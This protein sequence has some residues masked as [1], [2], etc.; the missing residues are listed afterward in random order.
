MQ[1]TRNSRAGGGEDNNTNGG[2]TPSGRARRLQRQLDA[3]AGPAGYLDPTAGGQPQRHRHSSRAGGEEGYGGHRPRA[4]GSAAPSPFDSYDAVAGSAAAH[5]TASNSLVGPPTTRFGLASTLLGGAGAHSPTNGFFRAMEAS[6]NRY[7]GA[8]AGAA[9]SAGRG[10]GSGGTGV[11]PVLL[12][13]P[14]NNATAL[15]GSGN[16]GATRGSHNLSPHQ[17]QQQQPPSHLRRGANQQQQQQHQH[18]AASGS[19]RRMV[20]S[21]DQLFDDSYSGTPRH[22][23]HSSSQQRGGGGLQHEQQQPTPSSTTGRALQP[24]AHYSYDTTPARRA[25][26]SSANN[27]YTTSKRIRTPPP[28][29]SAADLSVFSSSSSSNPHD[30]PPEEL[31]RALIEEATERRRRRNKQQQED[32][33]Q[34]PRPSGGHGGVVINGRPSDAL[35]DDVAR[36]ELDEAERYN[37]GY[38]YVDLDSSSS[39][40]DDDAE[41]DGNGMGQR[42]AAEAPLFGAARGQVAGPRPSADEEDLLLSPPSV[43]AAPIG[44]RIGRVDRREKQPPAPVTAPLFAARTMADGDDAA[45]IG[46]AADDAV[47]DSPLRQQA[48]P[49]ITHT[50]NGGL[51]REGS[52]LP[53]TRQGAENPIAVAATGE[54]ENFEKQSRTPAARKRPRE[55]EAVGEVNT[56]EAHTPPPSLPF[57]QPSPVPTLASQQHPSATNKK[58]SS[59]ANTSVSGRID[60]AFVIPL[61]P[62]RDPSAPPPSALALAKSN[63]NAHM[64]GRVGGGQQEGEGLGGSSGFERPPASRF[65]RPPPPR[66]RPTGTASSSSVPPALDSGV[67]ATAAS[68]G[69]PEK[70]LVPAPLAGDSHGSQ[71]TSQKPPS[72]TSPPSPR[73]EAITR[74][75]RLP[76]LAPMTLPG[77]DDGDGD[78]NGGE[79]QLEKDDDD[80]IAATGA[81]GDDTVTVSVG[82]GTNLLS[83]AAS[84][85]AA[86]AP[87]TN[88]SIAQQ[89]TRSNS[90]G[91]ANG[92]GS[93]QPTATQDDDD[94]LCLAAVAK[95]TR[96]AVAAAAGRASHS[97]AATHQ[98]RFNAFAAAAAR[99]GGGGTNAAATDY[100]AVKR[101]S[102]DLEAFSSARHTNIYN[103]NGSTHAEVSSSSYSYSPYSTY[104]PSIGRSSVLPAL[105]G[106]PPR[107]SATSYTYSSIFDNGGGSGLA[108]YP[109]RPSASGPKLPLRPPQPPLP[110]APREPAP[111]PRPAIIDRS[112]FINVG[113]SCYAASVFTM[114]LRNRAVFYHLRQFVA[115][116]APVEITRLRRGMQAMLTDLDA[117]IAEKKKASAEV[118]NNSSA[119]FSECSLDTLVTFRRSVVTIFGLS[120]SSAATCI[121]S[122][123][124]DDLAW[125]DVKS[126]AARSSAYAANVTAFDVN[127]LVPAE[128]TARLKVAAKAAPL[129]VPQEVPVVEGD[130]VV[131]PIREIDAPSA[132]SASYSL[133]TS[134]AATAAIIS[135]PDVSEDLSLSIVAPMHHQPP[136][137]PP[138]PPPIADDRVSSTVGGGGR[139]S[140]DSAY[141]PPHGDSADAIESASSSLSL[142]EASAIPRGRATNDGNDDDAWLAIGEEGGDDATEA[143]LQPLA[144]PSVG[145]PLTSFS[146]GELAMGLLDQLHAESNAEAEAEAT[147]T[148]AAAAVK[149]PA[150]GKPATAASLS[151]A[152]AAFSPLYLLPGQSPAQS[153]VSHQ[154]RGNAAAPLYR[155]AKAA[156]PP[157]PMVTIEPPSAASAMRGSTALSHSQ[158]SRPSPAEAARAT[159]LL[160]LHA[161]MLRAGEAIFA[162]DRADEAANEQNARLYEAY[163]YAGRT[164]ASSATSSNSGNTSNGSGHHNA[165]CTPIVSFKAAMHCYKTVAVP[166]W[167]RACAAA[168]RRH[169]RALKKHAKTVSRI[170][171]EWERRQGLNNGEEGGVGAGAGRGGDE[172][173]GS[174]VSRGN[175]G[176]SAA[177]PSGVSSGNSSCSGSEDEYEELVIEG[178]EGP[179]EA[180]LSQPPPP[181]MTAQQASEAAGGPMAAAGGIGINPNA[182]GLGAALATVGAGF[183]DGDQHDAPEFLTAVLARLEEEALALFRWVA[184]ADAALGERYGY[185]SNTGGNGS[186]LGSEADGSL[187]VLSAPH[188]R[189]LGAFPSSSTIAGCAEEGGTVPFAGLSTSQRA[190]LI[191]VTQPEVPSADG[192]DSDAPSHSPRYG[193]VAALLHLLQRSP[194]KDARLAWPNALFQGRLFATTACRAKGSNTK[195]RASA[196]AGGGVADAASSSCSSA[197]GHKNHSVDPFVTFT[198]GLPNFDRELEEGSKAILEAATDNAPPPPP[199]APR[200]SDYTTYGR[201]S[202]SDWSRGDDYYSGTN[203]GNAQHSAVSA[204]INRQIEFK[205]EVLRERIAAR[206]KALRVPSAAFKPTDPATCASSSTPPKGGGNSHLLSAAT[207]DSNTVPYNHAATTAAE[208]SGEGGG[209][210]PPFDLQRLIARG[211]AEDVVD[212]YTCDRCGDKKAQFVSARFALPM[213][214]ALVVN[215]KR[216][217]T[218]W[219]AVRQRVAI[220]KNSCGVRV[221]PYLTFDVANKH[222]GRNA[223]A[224]KKEAKEAA[225]RE[226]ERAARRRAEGSTAGAAVA[227]D[228]EDEVAEGEGRRRMNTSSASDS[229]SGW[230]A[231]PQAADCRKRATAV[232]FRHH[233]ALQAVVDHYGRTPFS[234][235]Y[236]A[237][238]RH[239]PPLSGAAA[240]RAGLS[241]VTAESL[242]DADVRSAV[243]RGDTDAGQRRRRRERKVGGGGKRERKADGV[244]ALSNSDDGGEWSGD[245][246]GGGPS[247]SC[248]PPPQRIAG[249]SDA[250]DKSKDAFGDVNNST[251]ALLFAAPSSERNARRP[252]TRAEPFLRAAAALVTD[253]FDPRCPY[254]C[255]SGSDAAARAVVGRVPAL[256]MSSRTAAATTAAGGS[257]TASPKNNNSSS[258]GQSAAA[259]A[260]IQ[261]FFS[262]GASFRHANDARVSLIGES[263]AIRRAARRRLR[264]GAD[265]AAAT[266]EKGSSGP[267]EE[268]LAPRSAQLWFEQE[269]HAYLLSYQ[270]V[271]IVPI[272]EEEE[273]GGEA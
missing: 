81:S 219:D 76:R 123:V 116:A 208:D 224:A 221:S 38:T 272:Y 13:S 128:V 52:S 98:Q 122:S 109:P 77:G 40:D 117:A 230:A 244:D 89:P 231:T 60:K 163:S 121:D 39:G 31:R 229:G 173:A 153:A 114:L 135:A 160:S 271:A 68:A 187:A 18:T 220:E 232:K 91:N 61:P 143:D 49:Q 126:D 183:F 16:G 129:T 59:S 150:V 248:T 87:A 210:K 35:L 154:S 192:D 124:D 254:V 104:V 234:G 8:G 249:G 198:V 1:P 30:R 149:K 111:P 20:A 34:T 47:W 152:P 57:S 24:Q 240:A 103:N 43:A 169:A 172:G 260:R 73:I 235:H 188:H 245:E 182:M 92:L 158:P 206:E 225:R 82:G 97:A 216:F 102:I 118:A 151:S 189:V 72:Q 161:A 4:G 108:A 94:D 5:L 93:R 197:C 175:A 156:P 138:P 131:V 45:T 195:G 9:G 147:T 62:S 194:M 28:S 171:A 256:M 168:R 86:A 54:E 181:Y 238:F 37:E 78:A 58:V 144:P 74:S 236:V 148:A 42:E 264:R 239:Q 253:P 159:P 120:S 48:Q 262:E 146:S 44:D 258:S 200:V 261:H 211:L 14:P 7:S 137:P 203:N 12:K 218:D 184:L 167:E 21:D 246:G 51:Q 139:D 179:L 228:S 2:S 266:A 223:K 190:W 119:P 233:Y 177:D 157:K 132:S 259:T 145:E 162:R 63:A 23:H 201:S 79:W 85:S 80:P 90:S 269:E 50:R 96:R 252:P 180:Y 88:S 199:P 105:G 10:Y 178:E 27:V 125:F 69:R 17:Q 101:D 19:G 205:L 226:K 196:V 41:D 11:P 247:R 255:D 213:P 166:R 141:R 113:N 65:E 33:Q 209:P 56:T 106:A 215:L 70:L 29:Q 191:A 185:S 186:G 53:L 95:D 71:P 165:N 164:A 140:F 142:V 250:T 83:L 212:G 204:D 176:G 227:L 170:T 193:P 130:D 268:D 174:G 217:R 214:P 270:L 110:P 75:P 241:E 3:A 32:E 99:V 273:E 242:L 22:N 155:V 133:S 6:N 243:A 251:A 25:N 46:N 265:E 55:G 263:E 134:V 222:A 15:H 257:S 237:A 202:L 26:S 66:T 84:A 136:P 115:Q 127:L 112:G 267:S 107:P 67:V 64:R 207:D 100:A 36:A